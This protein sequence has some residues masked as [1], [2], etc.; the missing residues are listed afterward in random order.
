MYIWEYVSTTVIY[1]FR[2]S[3]DNAVS[4]LVIVLQSP[5]IPEGLINNPV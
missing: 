5:G 3:I 2:M 4:V 1:N